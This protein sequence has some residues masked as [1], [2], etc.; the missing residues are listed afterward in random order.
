MINPTSL[1]WLTDMIFTVVPFSV[2]SLVDFD[3]TFVCSSTHQT[4][5]VQ[6]KILFS[7]VLATK[8]DTDTLD[9]RRVI[10]IV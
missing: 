3:G 9:P 5:L 6:S 7:K 1:A 2:L 4:L 8:F 10:M